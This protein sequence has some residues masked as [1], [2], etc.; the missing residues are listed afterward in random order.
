MS[1]YFSG[2]FRG[3]SV[4]DLHAKIDYSKGSIDERM[5]ISEEIV[6]TGF[7]EDYFDETFNANYNKNTPLSEDNNVCKLLERIGTYIL[8]S[9]EEIEERKKSDKPHHPIGY[10]ISKMNR[11]ASLESIATDG[12]MA[13]TIIHNI[14]TSDVSKIAANKT[15]HIKDLTG[16]N[17]SAIIDSVGLDD[18]DT[19]DLIN[20]YTKY[21]ESLNE[22]SS[23]KQQIDKIKM[24]VRK[25]IEGLIE[26]SLPKVEHNN[27]EFNSS[28][29][30]N[31]E[32]EDMTQK[33]NLLGVTFYNNRG[34]LEHQP[35]LLFY[36]KGM[37]LDV[38]D[39]LELLLHDLDK[40]VKESGLTEREKKVLTF[41][42]RGDSMSSVA[43][44]LDIST[45]TATRDK[46]RIVNKVLKTSRRINKEDG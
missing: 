2:K 1:N 5:K 12:E 44:E 46:Q 36:N 14:K 4:N 37:G 8:M 39:E 9:D 20:S 25:D 10:L 41:L 23:P 32:P 29:S 3:Y 33:H 26:N 40:V 24:G 11:E 22:S 7:F 16:D 42:R 35:G 38:N 17:V 45:R 21:Y 13:D 6:D 43:K 15:I 30:Y 18:K 27:L 19:I 31:V 34:S 28:N